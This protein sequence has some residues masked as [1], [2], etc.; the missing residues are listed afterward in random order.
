M[1]NEASGYVLPVK[2]NF[3]YSPYLNIYSFP[4]EWDYD[5]IAG[6]LP[7]ETF[8][9]VDSFSR[10]EPGKEKE[11]FTIPSQLSVKAG[12]KLIY[13]AL[14]TMA[15]NNV[16]LMVRIT[17]LL[18]Q[19][20]H[21]CIVSKGNRAA[22]FDLPPNCWGAS[23]LP[24]TSILPLVD[25][26]ITHAGNNTVAETFFAGKPAILLPVFADQFDNA[27]RI[28]EKG[29]AIRLDSTSFTDEQFLEAI[30]RLLC[31][32]KMKA[33]L[34]NAVKRMKRENRKEQACIRIENLIK[35]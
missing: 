15:S 24:Q 2:R 22:E 10:I 31:D 17:Q 7:K 1:L 25:L 34:E 12:D 4:R 30:E 33:K 8:F 3:G 14:G 18:G 11:T 28:E 21:K 6:P 20:A 32:E 35:N 9:A 27:Q 23:H 29:Y 13:L 16:A 26:V 19:T 5:D